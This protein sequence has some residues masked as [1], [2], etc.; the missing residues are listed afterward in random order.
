MIG[1]AALDVAV[2]SLIGFLLGW[3][4]SWIPYALCIRPETP[5][6]I[7]PETPIWV[8]NLIAAAAFFIPGAVGAVIGALVF[9]EVHRQEEAEAAAM[10]KTSNEI[11]EDSLDRI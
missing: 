1:R 11:A 2:C 3:F 9:R 4:F 8:C 10:R 7:R 5:I 6:W